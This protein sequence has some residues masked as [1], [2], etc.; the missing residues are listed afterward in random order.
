M[1]KV[2]EKRVSITVSAEQFDRVSALLDEGGFPRGYLSYLLDRC[3][4]DLED[5]ITGYPHEEMTALQE[6]QFEMF[7][8]RSSKK[9]TGPES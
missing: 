5:M 6:V 9:K 8:S 1:A 4:S 2:L 3:I 7:E